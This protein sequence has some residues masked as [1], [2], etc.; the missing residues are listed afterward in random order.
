[1]FNSRSLG[2]VVLFILAG[3]ICLIDGDLAFSAQN[4]YPASDPQNTGNWVLRKDMSDEFDGTSLDADK[5]LASGTNSLYHVN[6]KGR[7]PSQFVPENAIVEDGKLK[8]RTKWEPEYD[9]AEG[10][11]IYTTAAVISKN[12]FKYGYMEIRC[13]ASDVSFTS[14]FWTLGPNSELDV[15][16]F[17]GDSKVREDFDTLYEFCIHNRNLQDWQNE[18]WKENVS[19][20]WRVASGFHVYSCEWDENGL[21]F[22][23]DGELVKSASKESIGKFWC[24][25][26]EM[27]IWMDSEAFIWHGFPD[28][29][30]LPADYE[31]DYIR[32]WQKQIAS[33]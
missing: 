13:K 22:F 30:E 3:T 8:L 5:W 2:N 15:F 33:E 28:K 24:L 31:I 26:E 11:Y 32:V 21:K 18:F 17:V 10:H 4:I 23:A 19:L 20:P 12:T 27:N 9:F 16:E 14:S 6:W 7:R 1:M 25:T 29:D